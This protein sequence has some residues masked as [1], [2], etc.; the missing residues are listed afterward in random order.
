MHIDQI[1]TQATPEE[2][3]SLGKAWDRARISSYIGGRAVKLQQGTDFVLDQVKGNLKLTKGVI[4][5]PFEVVKVHGITK[6]RNYQKWV[7]IIVEPKETHCKTISAIPTYSHL[8]PGSSKISVGLWNNSCRQITV[9]AKSTIA[10]ISAAN[11]V[12]GKLASKELGGDISEGERQGKMPPKLTQEQ[13][14]N[15]LTKL[16]FRGPESVGWTEIDQQEALKFLT[17]YGVVFAEDN[18]D[19]G[20]HLW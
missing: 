5:Q 8:K 11:I 10:T 17:D 1:L 3:A 9:K 15:L 14:N 2:V 6:V 19:L 20:K 13:L 18:M 16:E 7:N 4:L 12:P